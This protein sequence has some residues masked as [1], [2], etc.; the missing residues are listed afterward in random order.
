MNKNKTVDALIFILATEL[1][2]ILASLL[3][4]NISGAY[5]QLVKPPF[6]PP[7]AI[8]PIVWTILY[9]L[10]GLS[11]YWVYTS[12]APQYE[13]SKAYL[14]WG[15]QLFVNFLWPTV[16]F[17]LEMRGMALLVLMVLQCLVLWMLLR[18]QRVKLSAMYLNLPYYV[19]LLYASYLNAGFYL[20]NR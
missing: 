1:V 20:L 6:A 5:R 9:A 14:A 13:K 8:F 19:W 16:F 4:G 18:F 3:S 2:G 7:G 12:R 10:M 15:V 17:R 11:L